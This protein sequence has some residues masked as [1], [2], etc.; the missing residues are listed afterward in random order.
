[1]RE[2]SNEIG[3]SA[4][5][6]ELFEYL[7]AEEGLDG[8]STEQVIP[9]RQQHDGVSLSFAQ[10]RL[11]F[12]DQLEPGSAAYNMPGAVWFEGDLDVDALERSLNEIVRRHEM[13]RT[14][15]R[16]E[17]GRPVQVIAGSLSL[18]LSFIDLS[19]LSDSETEAQRSARE[20]AAKP[21]D[22][23]RGPLLRT[24][25]VRLSAE[26]H[27]LL[28]TLHHI[29]ADGWSV[30]LLVQELGE[31][32]RAYR[33]GE[34]S[35][36]PE[37][38]LTY[39]DYA[40]WQREWLQGERLG[41]Q[42]AYW[43]KQLSGELPVL[44]LPLAQ[45]R[46]GEARRRGALETVR[47]SSG[48]TS[49]LR[50]LGRR[51]GATLFMTLLA[52]WK[53]LLSRLSGERD[54]V[55]GTP[56]AGRVSRE[57][58]PLIGFFVNTL[59][60]RTGLSDEQSFIEVLKR[61]REVCLEAYAH[62]EVPFERVVEELRPERELN[63]GPLFQVLFALQNTPT[64][65]LAL[66]DLKVTGLEPENP[67]ARFDLALEASETNGELDCR[68]TYDA[69]LFDA[70]MIAR[71]AHH[72]V[73]LLDAVAAE[74]QQRISVINFLRNEERQ[75]LL[76]DWNQTQADFPNALC[77]HE[78][79]ARQAELTPDA[80]AIVFGSERLSYHELNERA[81]QLAHHLRS[82]GGGP[83]KL[84]GIAVER[85]PEMIA[86]VLAI[87]KAGAAYVPLSPY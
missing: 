82:Q 76:L 81:N 69:D 58:E 78:L 31:L 38:G 42:L 47:V 75:Q 63:H 68:L 72:F 2:L 9:R 32:Y 65:D 39:A 57:L 23:T 41:E 79:F 85:S 7:L 50:E 30:T 73:N 74:P 27:L 18:P 86:G 16:T 66:E 33:S 8:V 24:T 5:E 6:L 4:E 77:I 40:V 14:T 25:L 11:W 17:R 22:L 28:V 19:E 84:I 62:Q 36:L 43:R 49:Q 80:T 71:L 53:I 52:A 15:F 46:A 55:V 51:E 61:V 64:Y 29:V 87:L 45:A 13:L 56:V 1:M 12:L 54:V 48:L 44:K 34:K 21:F 59:V 37:S 20:E 3:V 67:A 83:E 26:C 35:T 10:E 60:L 70:A